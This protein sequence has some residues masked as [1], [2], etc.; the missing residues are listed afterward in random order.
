MLEDTSA[1]ACSEWTLDPPPHNRAYFEDHLLAAHNYWSKVSN[2]MAGIDLSHSQVFP[3]GLDDSYIL[4]HDMLYYHPYI[5]TTDETGKLM[6]LSRDA[7][8][9]ADPDVNFGAFT[10]VILVHAGMGGDFAFALDPTP[11]NI[12]SAYLSDVDFSSYGYLDTDEIRLTDL[13]IIPES[14]NFLQYEET[15]SLFEDAQDPCFYQVGLNGTLA[16]MLGFHLGLPPLYN[17]E[18]GRSLVGGFALMDQG[19][20]NFHGIVPAYPDAF[21]RIRAGWTVATTAHIGDDVSLAVADPPVRVSISD[22]EYYLIENRQR[23][24]VAPPDMTEWIDSLSYDTVSVL[25]SDRGVVL[26]VDEQHAG[27][28]GNGLYIWHIDESAWYQDTNPNGGPDQLVDFVEADGAQDMGHTTQLIFADYLETGWWFD[29]WYAGNEGYFHLNRNAEIVGDSLLSFGPKT[30]P[31]TR[32]NDGRASHLSIENI[33]RNGSE[34][35]FSVRSD[36]LIN[37]SNISSFIGWGGSAGQIW[38][39]DLD[40]SAVLAC[41]IDGDS[42]STF[43]NPAISPAQIFNGNPNQGFQFS[44]PWIIPEQLSGAK[45]ISVVTGVEFTNPLVDAP[46]EFRDYGQ[47][48]RYLARQ[49]SQYV[50][51][52]WMPELG[53]STITPLLSQ[54]MTEFLTP[55]GF[56]PI[57]GESDS[58]PMP[59][60]ISAQ[61]QNEDSSPLYDYFD[62]VTWSVE[63]NALKIRHTLTD[64]EDLLAVDRPLDIRPMDINHDGSYELALFYPGQIRIITKKGVDW[65]GSPF[66][67]EP[68]FGS[69]LIAPLLNDGPEIFLR[70][71]AGYSIHDVQGEVLEKGVLVS[72]EGEPENHIRVTSASLFLMTGAELLTFPKGTWSYGDQY[73]LDSKANIRGDRSIRLEMTH[74]EQPADIRSGSVYNY[75]NPIKGSTT[76]IRAWLGDVDTWI[77]E[78]FSLSGAQ[79]AYQELTTLQKNSYNEWV[80]D[81]SDVSNGVFVAQVSAGSEAQ[82]IKI[83]VIR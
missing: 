73:W 35:S 55:P 15:R 44:E 45:F 18:T 57:Y 82:I 71:Q 2:G 72:S 13:I 81:A 70:H 17:A 41:Q 67:I 36:R 38:A 4:P 11:G 29:P 58:T 83:A 34:M 12:P 21:S 22:S 64:T 39:F 62:I 33:S 43:E 31:A 10:T 80:W 28:P 6:E 47:Y 8:T 42:L 14:Q 76:T 1:I 74:P 9:L 79:V 37:T 53:T 5:G 63:Q 66:A 75:P 56:L 25:L 77:V 20:N 46:R 3:G 16:L 61:G 59:V 19:S 23:N 26:D 24:L 7:L 49:E 32:A 69:P 78:I 48:Y 54:A 27:L 60:M 52:R 40:S 51:V 65:D 50:G 68:Y 30:T